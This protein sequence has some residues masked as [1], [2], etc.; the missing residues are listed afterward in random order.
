MSLQHD[1]VWYDIKNNQPIEKYRNFFEYV[2]NPLTENQAILHEEYIQ[3]MEN[4]VV[5]VEATKN[6]QV[7]GVSFMNEFDTNIQLD[8][9]TCLENV[10]S[11][12]GSMQ[13]VHEEYRNKGIAAKMHILGMGYFSKKYK[14]SVA[15]GEFSKQKVLSVEGVPLRSYFRPFSPISL[16]KSGFYTFGPEDNIKRPMKG[17]EKKTIL[18]YFDVLD[19][20]LGFSKDNLKFFEHCKVD[21]T[22]KDKIFSHWTK[23]IDS[24]KKWKMSL[25]RQGLEKALD[26]HTC[27]VIKNTQWNKN[28]IFWIR[29]HKLKTPD[30][31]V[32][33][34][35]TV[36]LWLLDFEDDE[37]TTSYFLA[38][39]LC[40]LEKE[41]DK[42][43]GVYFRGHGSMPEHID[44]KLRFTP[45]NNQYFIS[46]P[47]LKG[48][49]KTLKIENE[50][51]VC[52]PM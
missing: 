4:N 27:F 29:P 47:F 32:H 3:K 40:I 30:N 48:T 33:L 20:K 38:K 1:G 15:Y 37:Q 14:N 26:L 28:C 43:K 41:Y 35:G 21:E 42:M 11:Y 2:S 46:K 13:V 31:K 25:S 50:S 19:E 16:R 6:G 9:Q 23:V 5:V 12:L 52:V 10:P 49:N 39:T 17:K 36:V 18:K 51:Q 7:V 34:L 45:V 8:D 22:N 24:N 44:G